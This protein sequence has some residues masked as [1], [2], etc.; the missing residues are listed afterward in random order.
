MLLFLMGGR[1]TDIMCAHLAHLNCRQDALDRD[2]ACG[3]RRR[4]FG[5][6][7]GSI[8]SSVC[9]KVVRDTWLGS[10]RFLKRR[11]QVSDS[12]YMTLH[13]YFA[14]QTEKHIAM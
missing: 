6:C 7:V 12:V 10:R 14:Y 8:C 4:L 1:E 2:L 13:A 9:F 5:R 11:T 3:G